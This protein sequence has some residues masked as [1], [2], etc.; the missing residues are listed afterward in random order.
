MDENYLFI[1]SA[2]TICMFQDSAEEK[3]AE[4]GQIVVS[5]SSLQ[6]SVSLTP[7]NVGLS[8]G[9]VSLYIT[10]PETDQQTEGNYYLNANG[11]WS[12]ISATN[13][14]YNNENVEEF[15]SLS[16]KEKEV[17]LKIKNSIKSFKYNSQ[18]T[19][20]DLIHFGIMPKD[21]ETIFSE[22]GLDPNNY[23][24]FYQINNTSEEKIKY[25]IHYEQLL[26]FIIAAI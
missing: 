8:N 12:K 22:N 4:K 7:D 17:A 18:T 20:K 26:A 21:L 2:N 25:G 6:K 5:N 10:C 14:L 1:N 3:F 19:K 15:S 16:K 9:G 11:Q 13:H 23:S 24:L